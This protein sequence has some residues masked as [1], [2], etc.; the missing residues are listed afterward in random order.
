MRTPHHPP[1]RLPSGHVFDPERPRSDGVLNAEELDWCRHEGVPLGYDPA[2]TG[3]VSLLGEDDIDPDA[4]DTQTG[5]LYSRPLLRLRPW[6]RDEA[7]VMCALL[8]DPTLWRYLP[9]PYPGP[10]SA[11]LGAALIEVAAMEQHHEVRAVECGGG[12]VGQVRLL[13]DHHGA[14][15]RGAEISYWLGRAYWGHGIGTALVR[16]A[17]DDAFARHV[18]LECLRARVH[19]DNGASAS[20][21]VRAGYRPVGRDDGW[22]GFEHRRHA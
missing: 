10:L 16:E 13:F 21:L 12:V 18:M 8:D 14:D 9:E 6:R 7:A 17:T 1:V 11:E 20:V 4:P 2:Q 19:P 5:A 15:R 3:W 22:L